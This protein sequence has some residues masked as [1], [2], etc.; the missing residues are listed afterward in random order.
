[1][2]KAKGWWG[3]ILL[4]AIVVLA[5]MGPILS[6]HSYN[7]MTPAASN[8]A[9]S[10]QYWFGSDDLGRD[11]FTRVWQGARIS[12][13]IGV[14]AALIDLIVGIVWGGVAALSGRNVDEVMM[15]VA[16]ILYALPYLLV[17]ILLM[18]VL[19]QGVGTMILALT[20]T[21][22]ITMARIV[23]AQLL[24]IKEQEY[25]LA[26]QALGAGFHR[27]LF[28]HLLPNAN[29]AILTTLT[30]TVP[31][32]IF[33]EAFL[34][35]LGLGVCAP[36]ASLGA[37]ASDGLPALEYYPWRS[38]FPLGVISLIMLAFNMIADGIGRD[39]A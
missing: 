25:V 20:L 12:L 8:L 24:Q 31:T 27:V 22:W 34:S 18:V 9:P 13:F 5:V 7:G 38:L 29:V 32:A 14:V 10:S 19:D 17:V 6:S 3:V 39:D 23:R 33:T 1:M 4:A 15:R 21:G 30:L 11:I 35:F 2:L 36:I 37:M 26:A 28:R 16:D